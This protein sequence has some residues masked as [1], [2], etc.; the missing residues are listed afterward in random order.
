MIK[1]FQKILSLI[2]S[3]FISIGIPTSIITDN[4]T[5]QGVS[6]SGTAE[7][8]IY[9]QKV[10]AERNSIPSDDFSGH[11]I[12]DG[13]EIV[14]TGFKVY[15]YIFNYGYLFSCNKEV[16]RIPDEI[17]GVPVT[18]IAKS[19]FELD[20]HGPWHEVELKTL[21]IGNNVENIEKW[22]IYDVE[23]IV[24]GKN[25]TT[26]VGTIINSQICE[27]VY[28]YE[29]SEIHK[30]LLKWNDFYEGYTDIHFIDESH[31]TSKTA[32]IDEELNV[33]G[34]PSGLTK[35]TVRDYVSVDGDAIMEISD[36][37]ITTGTTIE[38]INREY[39]L[40][41]NTYTVIIDG[42]INGD[43][44]A[45]SAEDFSAMRDI[46]TGSDS[47]YSDINKK[48]AD[49]NGDGIVNSTDLTIMKSLLN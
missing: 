35:E 33:R 7:D 25:V 30:Y 24:I 44:A 45:V 27:N 40:I 48:A 6:A 38:L 20:T 29:N 32:T 34:L 16:L 5:E 41:D 14:I 42:D 15:D 49:L 39:G 2:M 28:C 17:D 31:L 18:T 26:F 11:Y 19:A 22:G 23:N 46:I 9:V 37:V 13:T 47:E 10:L 8:M 21:I 1:L 43:G 3:F 4:D 12:N 36:D